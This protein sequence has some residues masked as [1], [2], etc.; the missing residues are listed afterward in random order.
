[1]AN[2]E[3]SSV[4][5]RETSRT[6]DLPTVYQAY[7]LGDNSAEWDAAVELYHR[8]TPGQIS[9]PLRRLL[10][11]RTR[12][13]FV[14]NQDTGRVRVRSNWCRNRWCPLCA[15]A[16]ART[17]AASTATWVRDTKAPKFLTLTLQH[18][19]APLADQLTALRK[20][21]VA[22]KKLSPMSRDIR[23]GL[24]FL[25]VTHNSDTDEW[26]PHLH[27][28]ID[29][30][31]IPQKLLSKKWLQITHTSKILDIRPVKNIKM[32]TRYVSRYVSRPCSLATLP[33]EALLQLHD[34]FVGKRLAGTWGTA[35]GIQLTYNR[36]DASGTWH[37]IGDWEM[38]IR[39]CQSD[40][41]ARSILLAWQS[42][43]PLAPDITFV[44]P[45]SDPSSIRENPQSR[46]PPK[47]RQLCLPD[48][49]PGYSEDNPS[50]KPL[51]PP[52]STGKERP[53][54]PAQKPAA[55]APLYAGECAVDAPLTPGECPGNGRGMPGEWRGNAR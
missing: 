50:R 5:H 32:A 17:V 3:S 19:T 46:S 55:N 51:S 52:E 25:Q 43:E 30:E 26:H 21:F 4:Q 24:W 54:F 8:L 36:P 48:G 34:A 14:R 13:R 10:D 53:E 37:T 2:A 31:F 7:L 22:W 18:S 38:V 6:F 27:C 47:L 33:T 20:F 23:G 15:A 45:W 28:I 42:H 40:E 11:C 35:R 44:D 39:L 41:R 9:T 1:M 12:A 49:N 29:A 16:K